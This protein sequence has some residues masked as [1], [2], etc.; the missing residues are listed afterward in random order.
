VSSQEGLRAA[1]VGREAP[2]GAQ[3]SRSPP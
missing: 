2:F 3:A 1:L